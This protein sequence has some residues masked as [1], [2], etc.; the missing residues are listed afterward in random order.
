MADFWAS[1][2]QIYAA[3]SK[4]FA[5]RRRWRQVVLLPLSQPT[6]CRVNPN[7]KNQTTAPP[8]NKPPL[9]YVQWMKVCNAL[10]SLWE[11]GDHV[12]HGPWNSLLSHVICQSCCTQLQSNVPELPVCFLKQGSKWLVFNVHQFC[13]TQLQS[14]VLELSVC[15]L[16]QGSKILVFNVHQFCLHSSWAMEQKRLSAPRNRGHLSNWFSMSRQ[17]HR[18]CQTLTKVEGKLNLSDTH[19]FKHIFI[20][21]ARKYPPTPPLCPPPLPLIKHLTIIFLLLLDMKK[22]NCW[23]H[24][25][26][27]IMHHSSRIIKMLIVATPRGGRRR[28]DKKSRQRR[29]QTMQK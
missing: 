21:K 22:H 26:K 24:W 9:T 11:D 3:R 20:Y 18:S 8:P 2:I 4:R 23:W 13:C 7:A 29:V 28:K 5:C 1:Q 10:Q 14:N 16:K 25:N 12:R 19:T 17:P 6:I 27:Q 15:F